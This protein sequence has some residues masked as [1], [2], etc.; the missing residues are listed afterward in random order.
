MKNNDIRNMAL[1]HG[2]KL[3]QIAERLE[4]TDSYFSRMLRKELPSEKKEQIQNIIIEIVKERDL[5]T[6]ES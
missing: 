2:V 5:N 3:W 6:T 4:I 1:M